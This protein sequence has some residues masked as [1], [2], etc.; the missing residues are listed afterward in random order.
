MPH[1]RRTKPFSIQFSEVLRRRHLA[2]EKY[3]D[4]AAGAGVHPTQ[5]SRLA[6]RDAGVSLDVLDKIGT[7]LG[8]EVMEVRPGTEAGPDRGAD[9]HGLKIAA[10][11]DWLKREEKEHADRVWQEARRRLLQSEEEQPAA[12]R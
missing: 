2:G 9:E 4:I 6:N 11:L 3:K 5:V 1:P 7:Y 12:G 10:Y 8:L